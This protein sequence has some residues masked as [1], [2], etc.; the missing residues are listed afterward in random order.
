MIFAVL[1]LVIVVT[2]LMVRGIIETRLRFHRLQDDL[3]WPDLPETGR[4]VRF[5]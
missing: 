2:A 1:S 5:R 4:T 3:N